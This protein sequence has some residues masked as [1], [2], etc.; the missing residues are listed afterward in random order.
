MNTSNLKLNTTI[1]K[2]AEAT[3]TFTSKGMVRTFPETVWE[4]PN[5]TYYVR[6]PRKGEI[7]E[8]GTGIWHT[9]EAKVELPETLNFKIT[10]TTINGKLDQ[11]ELFMTSEERHNEEA[12]KVRK[13]KKDFTPVY[14]AFEAYAG[15][16]GYIP[17]END[18][19]EFLCTTKEFK[20]WAKET[21]KE[22]VQAV[23][24]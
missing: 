13:F 12:R 14:E 1:T 5:A 20:A 24:K 19:L 7:K 11:V 18:T 22:V 15:Q 21:V 23:T 16:S 17:V 3:A 2:T 4:Y 8:Y 9:E 6:G 10:V